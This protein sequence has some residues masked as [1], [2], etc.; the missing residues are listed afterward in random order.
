VS[1]NRFIRDQ[2]NLIQQK[3]HQHMR[4]KILMGILAIALP[5]G[6]VAAVQSAAFAGGPKPPPNGPQN[7]AVAGTVVFQTPGLSKNGSVSSTLKTSVT[8]ATSSFTGA[9]CSGSTG[10]LNISSKNT[11]C[12]GADDPTGTACEVKKTYSYD[13]ESSFASTGT[14][15]ILKSLK[16]LSFTLNGVTYSTKSTA[17]SS[18][19]CT[20]SVSPPGGIPQEVGFKI[21]GEVKGP[22]NDKGETVTLNACLGTDTGPGTTGSFLSDLGSGT[23]TIAGASIDGNTS[24]VAIS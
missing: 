4:R 8:T 10:T 13:T 15:S 22:K 12:K 3:E 11:K 21:S 9:G 16:K 14:S 23:G 24:S 17:A 7:C 5:I 1:G 6:T 20:D 19:G 18:I 2:T